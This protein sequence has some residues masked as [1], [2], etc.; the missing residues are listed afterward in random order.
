MTRRTLLSSQ[1][2]ARRQWTTKLSPR[3]AWPSIATMPVPL[4]R[5]IQR[6]SVWSASWI[7]ESCQCWSPCTSS[8]TS[9]ATRLPRHAWTTSKRN[10]A[11]R[12]NTNSTPPFPS[13]SSATCSCR[14][15]A[16]C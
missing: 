3:K 14:F 16:I 8:T 4:K 2:P 7:I 9:T 15:P 10:W 1:T 13:S 11:W 12:A 5:L 6:K